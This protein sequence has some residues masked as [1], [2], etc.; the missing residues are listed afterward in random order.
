M[1]GGGLCVRNGL[2]NAIN[3]WAIGA[4]WWGCVRNDLVMSWV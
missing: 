3:M 2:V 1:Y 4:W